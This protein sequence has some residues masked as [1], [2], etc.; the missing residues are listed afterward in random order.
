MSDGTEHVFGG[1]DPVDAGHDLIHDPVHT[2]MDNLVFDQAHLL[3]P[4]ASVGADVVHGSPSVAHAYWFPQ[5]GEDCVPASV[6]QVLSEVSGHPVSE[7]DVLQRMTQLGLELP[8]ASHGVPFQDAEQLLQSYNVPCHLQEHATMDDLK[9]YL[10]QGRSVILGVDPDPIWYPGEPDQHE[11]HAVMITAIDETT[12]MITLDD[13]GNP[14]GGNE[15]QVPISQFQTAWDE[16]QDMLVVTDQPT[17]EGHPGPVLT[18]VT[19]SPHPPSGDTPPGQSYTVQQGDTLWDIAERVYGD[20]TQ[21]P[22][23]AEASGISNPDHIEPGQVL[24]I[25]Q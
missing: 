6:T 4:A 7:Q 8:T 19:I 15:E 23:I 10:D 25:P 18:P 20:G 11:G 3:D 5:Q 2:P 24:T 21:Y 12:G 17:A 22:K 9:H 1:H 14:H 16:H 13:T